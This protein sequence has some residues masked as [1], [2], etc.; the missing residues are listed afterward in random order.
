MNSETLDKNKKNNDFQLQFQKTTF[1]FIN[2]VKITFPEYEMILNK[3]FYGILNDTHLEE[4]EI[5]D[6]VLNQFFQFCNLK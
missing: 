5:Q 4:K 1:E 3:Y 6:N 2:D